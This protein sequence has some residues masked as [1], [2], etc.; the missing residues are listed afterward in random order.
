[1]TY[2]LIIAQKNNCEL[3]EWSNKIV[4]N[5]DSIGGEIYKYTNNRIMNNGSI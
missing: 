1:M 2:D 5:Q 3:N 4:G